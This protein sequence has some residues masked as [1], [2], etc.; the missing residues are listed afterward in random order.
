[1]DPASRQPKI[2]AFSGDI[3]PGTRGIWGRRAVHR[4]S[5][6]LF[7]FLL[8]FGPI[9]A[10]QG[11]RSETAPPGPGARITESEWLQALHVPNL[12]GAPLHPAGRWFVVFFIGQECPV[13][14]GSIPVMNK[15]AK[16]FSSQG[17]T[18][19]GAYVDPT[20]DLVALRRHAG[21]YGISFLTADDRDHRLSRA[22]GATYTPEAAVFSPSGILLY[23]GRLD[24]R[25]GELGAARPSAT[26]HDLEDVLAALASGAPG[27]FKGKAGYGCAIPEA[28]NP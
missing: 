21:D 16:D 24:D 11:A 25:V 28:V 23:K 6:V 19:V 10:P 4:Q 5:H 3:F 9:C 20:A 8:G 22:A 15:L 1:M 26:H 27:P 7:I 2:G 17:F 14:N 13:S 18:F 12:E